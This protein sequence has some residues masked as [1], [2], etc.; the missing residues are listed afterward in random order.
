M[1]LKAEWYDD[2]GTLLCKS[3]GDGL[4]PWSSVS[5]RGE[6]ALLDRYREQIVGAAF[7][8]NGGLAE[9]EEPPPLCRCGYPKGDF[10][11]DVPYPIVTATI[12]GV[13]HW[14]NPRKEECDFEDACHAHG[15]PRYPESQCV[16]RR[17]HKK[18]HRDLDGEKW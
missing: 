1:R 7:C 8:S 6:L 5:K 4:M 17:G 2:D 16:K 3:D 10:V 15:H 18:R 12:H 14:Y 11:H 13:A 9:G